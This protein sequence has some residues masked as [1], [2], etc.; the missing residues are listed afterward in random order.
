M[1]LNICYRFTTYQDARR[2]RLVYLKQIFYEYQY[3]PLKYLQFEFECILVCDKSKSEQ[4]SNLY[5][6]DNE[7]II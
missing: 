4:K 5:I 6:I 7:I 1:H 3:H 2:V